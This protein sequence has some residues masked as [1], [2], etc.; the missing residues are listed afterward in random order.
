[1][2]LSR[3]TSVSKSL[4]FPTKAALSTSPL[5]VGSRCRSSVRRAGSLI[6]VT[7]RFTVQW[8][9]KRELV[10]EHYQQQLGSHRKRKDRKLT[11]KVD[12]M[13]NCMLEDAEIGCT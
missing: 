4:K 9:I 2:G 10:E 7:K 5:L 8:R 13:Q 3:Q 1:M 12:F 11:K 6:S